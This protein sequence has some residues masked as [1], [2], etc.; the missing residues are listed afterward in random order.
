[1]EITADKHNW[2]DQAKAIEDYFQT[3]Q[4]TYDQTDVAIPRGNQD[5]VDQFLFETKRGYCDNFSTSMVTLL[6]SIGIPARWAKGYT[7]GNYYG[8]SSSDARMYQITNN[9]AHSWV[10]VY[11]PTEGWVPFEPTKGF[12]HPVTYMQ[13]EEVERSTPAVPNPEEAKPEAPQPIQEGRED[14]K[15]EPKEYRHSISLW[16]NLNSVRH[17]IVFIIVSI[18]IISSIVWLS[19]KR[20]KWIPYVL[21]WMYRGKMRKRRLLKRTKICSYGLTALGPSVNKVRRFANMQNTLI[22][23]L[24]QMK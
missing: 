11:F 1:M 17:W 6:R 20:R 22:N 8:T 12:Y 24:I 5:Y 23:T 10:E 4:F 21:I 2:F 15:N 19:M 3:T 14:I 16:P 18:V 13:D 7:A 9:E